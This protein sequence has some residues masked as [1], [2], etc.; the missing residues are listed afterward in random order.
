LGSIRRQSTRRGK[1]GFDPVRE[2]LRSRQR[3]ASIWCQDG[4]D[5]CDQWLRSRE[6]LKVWP[7]GDVLAWPRWRG[8]RIALQPDI[9][10]AIE[11]GL[12]YFLQRIP[13]DCFEGL[14]GN[15]E[16][17]PPMASGDGMLRQLARI[18]PFHDRRQAPVIE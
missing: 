2:W 8:I 13:F 12:S 17:G 6:I 10:V 7:S 9:I 15:P 18:G 5:P 1:N 3:V 4:F 14:A 11:A 16:S